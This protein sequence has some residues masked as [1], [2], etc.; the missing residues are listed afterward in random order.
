M[1]GISW[2]GFNSIQVAMLRPPELKAIIAMH[3][4]DDL[5]HDD[6]HYIDGVF[7]ID[8][9]HLF[10]NHELALPRTPG[11]KIDRDYVE[12]RFLRKPWL[13]TY[14]S[15]QEDGEFW[16]RKSLR[17]VGYDKI[18][19][20]VY[21]I[22]GLLDGYRDPVIRLLESLPASL[23]VRAEI[24]PWSHSSPDD[25]VPGPNYEWQDE[26]IRWL[27]PYMKTAGTAGRRTSR[28]SQR[29]ISAGKG[30]S[31]NQASK[32]QASKNRREL[33]AFVRAGHAPNFHL[34]TSPGKWRTYRW[35]IENCYK[36]VFYPASSSRL[37]KRPG[38]ESADHLVNTA[39]SGTGAGHWWGDNS[40]DMADDDSHALVYD[41]QVLESPL[42]IVGMPEVKLKVASQTSQAFWSVRLEDVAPDGKVALVTGALVNGCHLEGRLKSFRLKPGKIYELAAALHFTTW[43][44]KKGHRIRLAVANAQFPMA[45]PSPAVCKTSLHNGVVSRSSLALPVVPAKAGRKPVFPA[46]GKKLYPPFGEAIDLKDDKPESNTYVRRNPDGTTAFVIEA[47]S[48]YRIRRRKFFTENVSTWT[49]NNQDPANSSY[50]GTASTEIEGGRERIRLK[51]HILVQSDKKYFHVSVSRQLSLNG[52]VVRQKTWSQS[53]ER[54]LG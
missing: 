7:H 13:F 35:P 14:M 4:S 15:N 48:A 43:T 39:G 47:R 44:F 23:N 21:I 5:Y 28:A 22:G 53:I 52:R 10:I 51:T 40:W 41:T 17:F 38:K 34:E 2:S 36:V 31:K 6:I 25:G 12:K 50:D 49:T 46:V 16:R 19:I 24:G 45:W 8:P 37:L 33:T 29:E 1:W 9:Y 18:D 11:Y 42:T 3:A 32:N 27:A 54:R 26:A 20:P 30:A